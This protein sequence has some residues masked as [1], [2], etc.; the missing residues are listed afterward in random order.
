MAAPS[1]TMRS[2]ALV[3]VSCSEASASVLLKRRWTYGS[4]STIPLQPDEV[5]SPVE[6]VVLYS[7]TITTLADLRR[8]S[9]G[10]SY[11]R[12]VEC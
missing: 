4:A 11:G 5:V 1:L 9:R 7:C 3:R 6:I 12:S 8:R 10:V 2:T